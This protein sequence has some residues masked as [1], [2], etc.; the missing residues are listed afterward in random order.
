MVYPYDMAHAVCAIILRDKFE[1]AIG[2]RPKYTRTRVALQGL[3]VTLN[4]YNAAQ[5]AVRAIDAQR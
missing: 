5:T 4:H 3:R 2:L 1:A